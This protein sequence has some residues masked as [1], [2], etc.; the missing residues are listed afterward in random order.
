M[1]RILSALCISALLIAAVGCSG[2]TV[3]MPDSN[4]SAT[5]EESSD[6]KSSDTS[7]ESSVD[8][9]SKEESSS[10][11]P[12][13]E[14]SSD[15]SSS[16]ES[17]YLVYNGEGYT[18]KA[19]SSKWETVA[20]D[21]LDISYLYLDEGTKISTGVQILPMDGE[22]LTLSQAVE[23][24][25]DSLK[26]VDGYNFKSSEQIK[27]NGNDAYLLLTEY[28]ATDDMM[29]ILDQ[30]IQ[31]HNNKLYVFQSAYDKEISDSGKTDLEELLDSFTFTEEE[32]N[33]TVYNGE[34]YTIKADSSK[35]K[36]TTTAGMEVSYNYLGGDSVTTISTGVQVIPLGGESLTLKQAAE[37]TI[38]SLKSVD[39][40]NFKS[41]E[42]IKIN[43]N[44]AYL[45]LT[46]Y[47]ATNNITVILDQRLQLRN[48][49]LYVFQSAY[50]PDISDSA[51]ADLEELLASFT[52]TD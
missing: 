23:Q 52:F 35:W 22:S 15:V 12:A 32:T 37:Q 39:S 45:L 1:K 2:N 21:V 40:Y 47:K 16:A 31:M 8:E 14:T 18:I 28:Q 41:S 11:E 26:S 9:T 19:D 25:I 48:G 3:S 30:R 13:I 46:E 38:N 49:K 4:S 27:I 29:V 43:G 24:T 36:T 33:Y 5:H 50:D 34:G 51:K 10:S 44:D 7:E 20:S 6:T 42:Q 17:E